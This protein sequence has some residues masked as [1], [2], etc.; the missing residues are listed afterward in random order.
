MSNTPY[1][2]L[3]AYR[4]K[5]AGVTASTSE[6]QDYYSDLP[7]SLFLSKTLC[8]SRLCPHPLSP[9]F[10]LASC[11]HL[12]RRPRRLPR[13]PRRL[14]RRS[15]PLGS[16]SSVRCRRPVRVKQLHPR[17]SCHLRSNRHQHSAQH[18]FRIRQ[19]GHQRALQRASLQQQPLARTARKERSQVK[20]HRTSPCRD[21]QPASS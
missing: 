18:V 8:A 3:Q 1:T 6:L 13:R 19:H 9:L 17:S 20:V 2:S 4:D 7:V 12:P 5:P 21:A 15:P 16:L 14:T 10:L 11:H